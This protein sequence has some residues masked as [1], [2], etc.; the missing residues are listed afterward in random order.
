MRVA[1]VGAGIAGLACAERLAD[2]QIDA[3][4]FDKGKRPGGRLSSLSIEE[5]AWDFGAPYLVARDPL[6]SARAARWTREGVL[7]RWWSGPAGAMVGTPSMGGLVGAMCDNLDVRFRTHVNRTFRDD[8]GWHVAGDGF[9]E[10]PFYAVLMATPAEQA[11]ALLS[12]HDLAMASEAASVR[13]VACWTVM[14]SFAEPLDIE[15]TFLSDSPPLSWA[16]RDNTKPDRPDREC[17]VIQADAAWSRPNL[18]RDAKDVAND[19]LEA[20]RQQTNAD[21]LPTIFLK[22]HRW[23]YARPR[24]EQDL[25]L[26]NE[27]RRLGACGDWCRA[28]T[29]E[30]AWLSGN[31]L[32]E[33]VGRSLSGNIGDL[34]CEAVNSA[35]AAE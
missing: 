24:G 26:W 29:I 12:L 21:L 19:L 14:A 18:E 9:Q 4:L 35:Q 13:S 28:P 5:G 33:T 8:T 25:L 31:A 22:A 10:G 7:A 15:T 2:Y 16:A 30:G 34:P 6:F 23:R 11:A 32:A 20:F 3:V 17:W 1:I 27:E